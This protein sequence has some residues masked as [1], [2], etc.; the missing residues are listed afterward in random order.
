MVSIE[1][2]K[3]G[4]MILVNTQDLKLSCSTFPEPYARTIS[5]FDTPEIK[6]DKK[7]FPFKQ[8][9]SVD[10]SIKYKGKFYNFLFES[11]RNDF[12]GFKYDGSSIPNFLFFWRNNADT[13]M[14]MP[15]FFHDVC[16]N[17]KEMIDNN[18]YLSSLIF[19]EALVANGMSKF[20]ANIIF[21]FV[22][23]FQKT[24]KW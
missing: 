5:P 23:N 22:D 2:I 7:K 12:D 21:F 3:G 15:A 20:E 19:K 1:S 16:C 13:M 14:L 10:F 9:V 18:R 11:Y 6:E 4:K 24:K 17:H 8:R